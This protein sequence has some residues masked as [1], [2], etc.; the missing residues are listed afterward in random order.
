MK[1]IIKGGSASFSPDRQR[2]RE[3]GRIGAVY[4]P[5]LAGKKRRRSHRSSLRAQTG[6]K[7]KKKVA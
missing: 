7:K 1:E 6:W 3:E 4:G 5:K 2:E